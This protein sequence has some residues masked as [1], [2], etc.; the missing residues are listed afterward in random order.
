MRA[1]L[2]VILIILVTQLA[3]CTSL[4]N[5]KPSD[6]EIKTAIMARGAWNPLVG[7][8]ELE[9]VQIEQL[10]NFNI[11]KK[12]WPVKARVTTKHQTA[13]LEYQVFRDDFGKWSARLAD[14]S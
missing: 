4:S 12:C 9:S 8:I 3:G 7:R 11:E 1:V 2:P 14:R 6:E 10:G 13:V 5:P